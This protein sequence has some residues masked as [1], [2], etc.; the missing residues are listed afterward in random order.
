MSLIIIEL[1]IG[2]FHRKGKLYLRNS[3]LDFYSFLLCLQI[4]EDYENCNDMYLPMS[5]TNYK[6]KT[7]VIHFH[8]LGMLHKFFIYLVK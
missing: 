6:K 7:E 1:S 8:F 2:I 3:H 5:F 4:S